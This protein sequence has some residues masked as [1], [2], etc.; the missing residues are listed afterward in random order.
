M[1]SADQSSLDADRTGEVLRVGS[2]CTGFGGLDLA[3]D[4]VLGGRLAWYAET[5]PHANTVL[6]HHWPEVTNLGDIRTVDWSTVAPVDIV[7]AGF[8]CQDISN[9]GKRAGITG[10]HSG[11]WTAVVAAVRALRPPLVYLEN[12]A[13]L[14]RRGLD[15]VHAD[16]AAIGY[17]TSWLCL[18][19]SD[20]GAAHRRDRLFLL[21]VRADLLTADAHAADAVR[22]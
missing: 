14:R 1:S 3:V 8:P 7:T 2:L 18:R 4:M 17:D 6:A 15:V 22:P 10:A 11:L 20:I 9:A 19:A 12:V 13:A 21:A 5:D 16:L